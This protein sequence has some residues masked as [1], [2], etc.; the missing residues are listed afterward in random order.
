M[1][2]LTASMHFRAFACASAAG[3]KVSVERVQVSSRRPSNSTYA[4]RRTRQ[5]RDLGPAIGD[6]H[7]PGDVLVWWDMLDAVLGT[8]WAI[9]TFPFRANLHPSAALRSRSLWKR[10]C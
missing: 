3:R 10:E 4:P 2:R 8:L 1:R 7:G 9:L 6:S 5:G